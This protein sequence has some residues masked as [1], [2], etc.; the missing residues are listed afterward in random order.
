MENFYR[1]GAGGRA[2]PLLCGTLLTVYLLSENYEGYLIDVASVVSLLK[3]AIFFL[4][5]PCNLLLFITI[6]LSACYECEPFAEPLF[7]TTL[8]ATAYFQWAWLVPRLVNGKMT[9]LGLTATRNR[10]DDQN[11]FQ[12]SSPP[13]ITPADH[14]EPPAL[15]PSSTTKMAPACATSHVITHFDEV[16]RTPVERML[17]DVPTPR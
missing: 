3:V 10:A 11:F 14:N 1:S 8:V 4:S 13:A 17:A 7:W 16:G 5:F 6:G 15:P 2:W 12:S 9:T